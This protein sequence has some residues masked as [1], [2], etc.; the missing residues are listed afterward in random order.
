MAPLSDFRVYA[1]RKYTVNGEWKSEEIELGQCATRPN[2]SVVPDDKKFIMFDENQLTT[3]FQ[4]F[5]YKMSYPECFSY[6]PGSIYFPPKIFSIF[7]L[8]K[9]SDIQ[10]FYTEM[11]NKWGIDYTKKNYILKWLKSFRW[12]VT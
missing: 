11:C 1:E 3:A 2:S 5:F 9:A 4:Q 12:H 10:E 7:D 8:F 6:K